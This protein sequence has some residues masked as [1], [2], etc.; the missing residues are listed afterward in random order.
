MDSRSATRRARMRALA[1]LR[2]RERVPRASLKGMTVNSDW[3]LAP[4]SDGRVTWSN[5]P[6]QCKENARETAESPGK[7]QPPRSIGCARPTAQWYRKERLWMV[8]FSDFSLMASPIPRLSSPTRQGNRERGRSRLAP[9]TQAHLQSIGSSPLLGSLTRESK[10]EVDQAQMRWHAA[11]QF[12]EGHLA[13]LKSSMAPSPIPTV[14]GFWEVLSPSGNTGTPH[15]WP[16][17]SPYVPAASPRP[18]PV[19]PPLRRAKAILSLAARHHGP[20]P[21]GK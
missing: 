15:Q 6:P 1:E 9:T 11:V 2:T 7:S 18:L 17:S 20:P 8:G 19:G 10:C 12:Q 13:A 3:I 14:I 16:S 4:G 5:A 21:T